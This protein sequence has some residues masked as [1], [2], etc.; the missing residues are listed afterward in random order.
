M[1]RAFDNET[2]PEMGVLMELLQ[3][4][5]EYKSVAAENEVHCFCASLYMISHI[6]ISRIILVGFTEGC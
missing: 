4:T 6:I 1:L 2:C 5:Q 3:Q